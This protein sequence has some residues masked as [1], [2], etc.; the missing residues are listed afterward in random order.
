MKRNDKP[1]EWTDAEV[2][3]LL[4]L[5]REGAGAVQIASA[6]DRYI[7]SV[8]RVAENFGLQLRG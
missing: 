2:Q 6:L 4:A 5:S 3:L 7:S 1:K 8:K